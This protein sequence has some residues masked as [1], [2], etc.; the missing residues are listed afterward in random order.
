[1]SKNP[2]IYKYKLSIYSVEK[3][4][5]DEMEIVYFSEVEKFSENYHME[6]AV[7]GSDEKG[8]DDFMLM[9]A[10]VLPTAVALKLAK[11][12]TM[13]VNW[14]SEISFEAELWSKDD[15]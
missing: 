14:G 15:D 8:L 6:F 7:E 11:L 3:M 12:G 10:K 4:M 13:V 2:Y 1:M 5:G 9:M